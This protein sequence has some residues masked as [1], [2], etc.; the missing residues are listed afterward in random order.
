MSVLTNVME[1][2]IAGFIKKYEQM[3]KINRQINMEKHILKILETQE[4]VIVSDYQAHS[5]YIKSLKINSF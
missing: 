3:D 2:Y 4:E 5:E 1:K